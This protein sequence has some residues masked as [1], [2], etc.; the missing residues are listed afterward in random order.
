MRRA[1]WSAVW[2]AAALATGCGSDGNAND[3]PPGPL[4]ARARGYDTWHEAHHQPLYGATV[5]VRFTDDSLSEVLRYEGRGDSTIWTGTYLASQALR[6]SVTNDTQARANVLRI[7]ETLHNHLKVTGRAGFIA[8]YRA[9]ADAP[10]VHPC[11]PG[12]ENCHVVTEGPFA[13][14]LWTGNTSRD[15]YTGWFFG[16]V[17]AYD[18]VDDEAMRQTIRDDVTEVIDAVARQKYLIVDVDGIKT[19]AGPEALPPF[20]INWHL[21]AYHVAGRQQDLDAVLAIAANRDL[22][23]LTTFSANNRYVQFYGNNLSHQNYFNAERLSRDLPEVHTLIQTN[24]RDQIH[25]SVHLAHNAFFELIH[26]SVENENDPAL[27]AAILEDIGAFRDA[28]NRGYAV[29]PPKAPLDPYSVLLVAL[30]TAIP[31]LADI[32]GTARLQALEAYPVPYQCSTDF[33]W[34]RNPFVVECDPEDPALVN[35]GVDYLAAYWM[36]RY[37]GL[38]GQRD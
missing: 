30:Q 28:P 12:D 32:I 15:Q 11:D 36:A 6:Y 5:E 7:V 17:L 29:D 33:L 2:M 21:V 10:G 16:M 27:D 8:R 26:R 20:A 3:G 19:T 35:P 14:D 38:I 4:A 31:E 34:Q 1:W 25:K 37:Q 23:E 24:F 13:G 18:F 9:P 22:Y